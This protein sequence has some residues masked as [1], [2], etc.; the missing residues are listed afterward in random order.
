MRTRR[1]QGFTLIEILTV[2]IIIGVLTS[3]LLP[4]VMSA[5]IRARV[6]ATKAEI[7]SYGTAAEA[8]KSDAG[9]YPPDDYSTTGNCGL[10]FGVIPPD[11]SLFVSG[12]GSQIY[13][14]TRNQSTRGLVF[15]IGATFFIRGKSYGPYLPFRVNRLVKL[16]PPAYYYVGN[17][18]ASGGIG[19][20]FFW[21]V[22][23][24]LGFRVC[25][26]K[27]WFDDNYV[28]DSHVPEAKLILM[29]SR[30]DT[31][32]AHNLS[33]FDMFSF[34]PTYHLGQSGTIDEYDSPPPNPGEAADDINNWQ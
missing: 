20:T 26:G 16:D 9:I 33:S 19:F 1:Q 12:V 32:H 27:D 14:D 18:P 4:V 6:A 17:S 29:N 10:I 28:Y 13:K 5:R 8:F 34:G 23:D 15:W 24:T 3:V 11:P 25:M 2:I 7:A 30:T 31:A 21:P 22:N